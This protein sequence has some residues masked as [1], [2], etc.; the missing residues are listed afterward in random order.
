M[1][2]DLGVRRSRDA[3]FG[4]LVIAPG[5]GADLDPGDWS[6]LTDLAARPASENTMRRTLVRAAAGAG[7]GRTA[8]V[9]RRCASTMCWSVGRVSLRLYDVTPY[10]M[11][12]NEDELR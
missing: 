3:V 7:P 12:E 4:D 6:V 5:R 1:F 9:S 2:A 11:A 10:V 8:T